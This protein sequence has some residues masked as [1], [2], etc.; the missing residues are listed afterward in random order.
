[1]EN[2][3]IQYKC[4]KVPRP[5]TGLDGFLLDTE[6]TGRSF[7]GL[8]EVTP[9]WGSGKQTKLLDRN[10]FRQYFELVSQPLVG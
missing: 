3:R 4:F 7:N 9:E 5:G 6:Y 8:F 2:Y 1:M 10:I